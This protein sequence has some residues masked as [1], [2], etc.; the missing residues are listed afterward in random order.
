MSSE[1]KG[2]LKDGLRIFNTLSQNLYSKEKTEA[3]ARAELTFI[4]KKKMERVRNQLYIF[5][6]KEMEK[7]N[8][9]KDFSILKRP[10]SGQNCWFNIHGIHDEK[11]ITSIGEILGL[12]RMT[13][14][15]IMDT[16]ARPKVEKYEHY[17]FFGI[18]SILKRVSG[19]MHMEQISFL[20]T[21][22][23]LIS[24]QEEVGDHFEGIRNK[25]QE[26]IG[27][28]RKGNCDYLL[29]QM[30][31]AILDNF[32]ETIDGINSEISGLEQ[33]I[34]QKPD[35]SMQIQL[36]NYTQTSHM[37]RKALSP[38]KEALQNNI[39]G[40]TEL[41]K[42]ENTKYFKDLIY[43]VTAAIEEVDYTLS[44]LEGLKNIYFSQLSQKMNETM[45]VLTLVATIFIPLTFIA[46]I[47]GMNFDVMPELRHPLGYFIT[48]GVMSGI[49]I[50]MLIFFKLK[51][52]L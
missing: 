29:S 4:G 22:Q 23:L 11:I 37:I 35:P 49:A 7:K 2:I 10:S 27:F 44:T 12:E 8:D 20:L 6:E 51:K 34:Q 13:L 3:K 15:Q 46:G 17:I 36:E 40:G 14:R 24:F 9:I 43:S 48:L 31:D 52:W 42:P 19:E 33:K 21:N 18:K 1:R 41:I 30:I 50:G 32:Y 47:Y 26:G 16:T 25:M 38:L 39:A 5:N 45:K 28:I